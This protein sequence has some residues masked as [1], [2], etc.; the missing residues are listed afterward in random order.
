MNADIQK[1]ILG[2]TIRKITSEFI[3]CDVYPDN[4]IEFR[5]AYQSQLYLEIDNTPVFQV[6]N[7]NSIWFEDIDGIDYLEIDFIIDKTCES[8][9]INLP[10]PYLS[11]LELTNSDEFKVSKV[12]VFGYNI[13]FNL[14]GPTQHIIVFHNE[15]GNR[16]LIRPEPTALGLCVTFNEH[17]IN[18]FF[19]NSFNSNLIYCV[20]TSERI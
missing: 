8:K 20:N 19:N 4:K 18:D 15:N 10:I 11:S 7:I 5:M 17:I 3:I 6:L 13:E 9:D 12:E 2:N 16:L 1:F 14:Q